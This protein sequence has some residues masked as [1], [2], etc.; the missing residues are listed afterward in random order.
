MRIT[1]GKTDNSNRTVPLPPTALAVI[2]EVVSV[3]P[4]APTACLFPSPGPLHRG[5]PITPSTFAKEVSNIVKDLGHTQP[6]TWTA[7]DLR[8]TFISYLEGSSVSSDVV[9]RLVGH[10][11]GDIHSRVYDRSERLEEMRAAVLKFEA[12]VAA[13]RAPKGFSNILPLK[14][15]GKR[16]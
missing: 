9:R 8:R 4:A 1:D 6:T 10:S 2:R 11:A 7:H 15:K 5:E 12:H 14:A 13:V 3:T 16:A